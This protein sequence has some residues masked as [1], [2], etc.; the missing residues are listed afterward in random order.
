MKYRR[1]LEL[2]KG[3]IEN[4]IFLVTS[5]FLALFAGYLGYACPSIPQALAPHAITVISIIFGLSLALI[6]IASAPVQI[7]ARFIPNEDARTWALKHA[8]RQNS[9][10]INRQKKLIQSFL[11]TVTIGLL[12]L[13]LSADESLQD[14]PHAI[15]TAIAILGGVFTGLSTLSM[16]LS[17]AIPSILGA[18]LQRDAIFQSGE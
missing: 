16:S 2:K 9:R 4:S 5:F 17:F 6:S 1:N 11:L 8:T 3:S 10:L 7:D 18:V 12:F 14:G 13:A 15:Q